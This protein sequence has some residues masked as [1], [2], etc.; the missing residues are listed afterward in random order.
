MNNTNYTII[1]ADK[2]KKTTN[3]EPHTRY[4]LTHSFINI[5]IEKK[6]INKWKAKNYGAFNESLLCSRVY[7]HLNQYINID[8]LSNII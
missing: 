6:K 5:I 8:S 4:L 3:A 7:T 2:K 1:V